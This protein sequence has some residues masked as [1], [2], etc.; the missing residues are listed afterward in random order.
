MSIADSWV[1]FA[2]N[3]PSEEASKSAP[4]ATPRPPT[5]PVRVSSPHPGVEI[6]RY[7]A[8]GRDLLRD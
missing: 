3:C 7:P 1:G 8:F 5:T 2:Q 4:V 6:L